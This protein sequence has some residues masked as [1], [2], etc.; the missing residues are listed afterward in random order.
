MCLCNQP[1]EKIMNNQYQTKLIEKH[2]GLADIEIW[3]G[4]EGYTV[5]AHGLEETCST[6]KEARRIA[7]NISIGKEQ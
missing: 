6:L 3:R 2:D 7:K 5:K 4:P 1:K